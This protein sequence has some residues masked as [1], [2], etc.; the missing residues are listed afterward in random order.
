[1]S[2]ALQNK[3]PNEPARV[4]MVI[5]GS[6]ETVDVDPKRGPVCIDAD[7][8]PSFL[9]KH[10]GGALVGVSCFGTNAPWPDMSSTE[11]EVMLHVAAKRNRAMRENWHNLG[12][13]PQRFFYF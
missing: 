6:E 3:D 5:D 4:V 7:G 10:H 8:R 9:T 1:M 2:Y 11:R 12:R 13:Q